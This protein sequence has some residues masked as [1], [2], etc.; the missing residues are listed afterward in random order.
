MP[1]TTNYSWTTP[2]DTDLVKDGASAIRTLGTAID[3]TVFN[4]ANAA[5]QKSVIDAAGDLL[6]GTAN[7]TV[8]K[9]SL[10]TANQQL[11]V[12]SGA[13]SLEYFTP[14]T[15]G[16]MTLISEQVASANSAI[17]FNSISGSYKQ[18]LLIWSGIKHSGS[19]SA[20]SIR[21]NNSSSSVYS[22]GSFGA[23]STS[24]VAPFSTAT[25]FPNDPFGKNDNGY[26][27]YNFWS[28][29]SLLID[30]YASSTKIKTCTLTHSFADSSAGAAR[31]YNNLVVFNDTTAVTSLNIVR[32][33]GSATITN[34]T[35]S[36]IR[37]YGIS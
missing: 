31:M 18:L 14:A 35:N 11:R 2:A 12:N 33:S 20:F 3:T 8:G 9:L 15:A 5:V 1:T 24:L 6:I 10:G 26:T 27:T 13:T 32:L 29:G 25:S 23:E 21:L 36:S 28:M 4:N 34:E 30:N 17:D 16:G 37:L 22:Y 7:D 19:G